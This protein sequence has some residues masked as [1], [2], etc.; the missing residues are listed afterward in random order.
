MSDWPLARRDRSTSFKL[1]GVGGQPLLLNAGQLLPLR[2]EFA[3]SM[4][5]QREC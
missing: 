5:S 3:R 1:A 2:L 4:A